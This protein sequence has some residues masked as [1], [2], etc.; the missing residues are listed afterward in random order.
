MEKILF[1]NM[2]L[3]IISGFLLILLS[4]LGYVL[5]WIEDF[6]PIFVGIILAL[7]SIKRFIYSFK[8]QIS[9]NGALVL[10]IEIV[11]DLVFVFLLIYLQNYVYIFIGLIIYI[12]GV[13]Y[14]VMNYVATRKVRIVQYLFNIGYITI[15]SFLMFSTLDID[16]YMIIG[17]A[18][19]LLVL[20]AIYLENGVTSLNKKEHLKKEKEKKIE[21]KQKAELKSIENSDKSKKK[22]DK[23]ENEVKVAKQ[24][25]KVTEKEN[26][27][28]QKMVNATE[29]KAEVKSGLS[30][31]TVVELRQLAK[32]KNIKGY[33]TLTKAE[34]IS[35]LQE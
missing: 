29:K 13:A 21:Q 6:L 19:V 18:F 4:I 31:K 5:H 15:G 32:D 8:K 22:I 23:L 7:L 24:E 16:L 20:G 28:L 33:S 10:I 3:N 14:L 27:E 34:L 9:K 1:K 26:K 25:Q 35:K 12:R 11:L 2:Y 30:G 17:I